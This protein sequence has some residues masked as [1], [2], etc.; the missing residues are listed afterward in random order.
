MTIL[1]SPGGTTTQ[2]IL[3]LCASWLIWDDFSGFCGGSGRSG[4]SRSEALGMRVSSW[5]LTREE[6]PFRSGKSDRTPET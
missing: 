4:R 3:S 5:E 6:R 2:R 1:L